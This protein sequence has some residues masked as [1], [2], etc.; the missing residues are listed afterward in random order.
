MRMGRKL[1]L[2]NWTLQ[3]SR[4]VDG[5]K[6]SEQGLERKLEF[7][8]VKFAKWLLASSLK[9]QL[10]TVLSSKQE[11]KEEVLDLKHFNRVLVQSR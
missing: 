3:L 9:A 4:L 11:T 8:H 1:E 2:H 6:I 7:R 10:S 5:L